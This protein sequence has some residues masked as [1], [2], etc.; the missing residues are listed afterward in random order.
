MVSYQEIWPREMAL[1]VVKEQMTKKVI[2]MGTYPMPVAKAMIR[3]LKKAKKILG[4]KEFIKI[5]DNK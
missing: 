5:L 4:H 1:G 3:Y 2:H